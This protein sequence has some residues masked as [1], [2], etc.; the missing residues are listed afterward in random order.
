MKIE[1]DYRK[2]GYALIKELIPPRWRRLS[3]V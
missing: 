3:W 1:G 2:D